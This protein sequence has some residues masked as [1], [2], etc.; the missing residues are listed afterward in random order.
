MNRHLR[1]VNTESAAERQG[2]R[3]AETTISVSCCIDATFMEKKAQY[4][5]KSQT[6]Q[7]DVGVFFIFYK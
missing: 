5:L 3:N 1:K 4:K 6:L 7:R 2:Q